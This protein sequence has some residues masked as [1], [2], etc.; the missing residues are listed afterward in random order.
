MSSTADEERTQ[1]QGQESDIRRSNDLG[2]DVDEIPKTPRT[3][4]VGPVRSRLRQYL[5]VPAPMTAGF[6]WLSSNPI[7]M[8][9]TTFDER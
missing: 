2:P 7:V 1:P 8:Y 9:R 6:P 5:R 4:S 3:K